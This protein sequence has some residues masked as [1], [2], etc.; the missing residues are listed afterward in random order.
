MVVLCSRVSP[1]PKST[2]GTILLFRPAFLSTIKILMKKFSYACVYWY[3]GLE[4]VNPV[5]FLVNMVYSPI[6][7]TDWLI[8]F[9]T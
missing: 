9:M 7:E 6:L 1:P 3:D 5:S 8:Y 2:A 4:D